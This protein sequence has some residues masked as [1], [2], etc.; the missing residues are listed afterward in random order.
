LII[1][2]SAPFADTTSAE[3]VFDWKALYLWKGPTHSDNTFWRK[4]S[5]GRLCICGRGLHIL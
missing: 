4:F 5:T 3:K 1:F 2:S